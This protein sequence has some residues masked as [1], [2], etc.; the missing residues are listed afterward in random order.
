MPRAPKNTTLQ[1]QS[2]KAR[3][4]INE[5]SSSLSGLHWVEFHR[6]GF[7]LLPDPEDR[8]PGV[9][10]FLKGNKMY[11]DQRFCSCFTS[12]K[13]TCPHILKLVDL[14]RAFHKQLNG[15]TPEEHFR[16][17]IWYYLARILS[18]G[19]KETAQSVQTHFVGQK[20][21]KYLKVLGSDGQEMLH[22]L[23]NGPDVS[24]FIERFCQVTKEDSVPHR[25]ALLDK[26]ALM[27]LSTNER[28]MAKM[29][30]KSRRQALE[31]NA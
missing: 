15:Q 18:D 13:K 5:Q 11:E 12:R 24:R 19:C 7:A 22:Y 29:G 31:E 26:L 17:S 21:E 30:F 3:Q 28:I 23:S 2:P 4:K 25:A 20:P 16:S 8:R 27:T 1:Q 6:H 10:F 14:Y 9:A